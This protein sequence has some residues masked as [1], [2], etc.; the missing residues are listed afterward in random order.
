[1]NSPPTHADLPA[2]ALSRLPA[3]R[4]RWVGRVIAANI[5][6]LAIALLAV[7]ASIRP[8]AAGY[9]THCQLGLAPCNYRLVTGRPCP[10]CGM[11]TAFASFV[12][13]DLLGALR[14]Q[15]LGTVL[16]A[17]TLL[18]AI[19]G[20]ATALFGIDFSPVLRP[21][22]VERIGWLY[23]LVILAAVSWGIKTVTG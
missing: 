22:F 16:A 6:I 1:M 7:A 2:S 15:L 8:D 5:A 13:G 3:H 4:V 18:A 11:T 23:A 19:G 20:C 14:A 9:G 21:V 12:H 17:L 10:T